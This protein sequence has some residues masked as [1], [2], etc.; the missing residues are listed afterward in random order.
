[1]EY[2]QWQEMCTSEQESSLEAWPQFRAYCIE[3]FGSCPNRE[4]NH[5]VEHYHTWYAFSGVRYAKA[6]KP[7]EYL[8]LDYDGSAE[9]TDTPPTAQQLEDLGTPDMFRV[10][11]G[12]F[13]DIEEL[14]WAGVFTD[15][16]WDKIER[17]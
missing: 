8:Y 5:D 7:M 10:L 13:G 1:M 4:N 9:I 16:E 15:G 14:H 2:E 12:K 11:R 17:K 6:K 3:R